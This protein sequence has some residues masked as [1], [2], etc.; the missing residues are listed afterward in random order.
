MTLAKDQAAK[1]TDLRKAPG[2]CQNIWRHLKSLQRLGRSNQIIFWWLWD[3]RITFLRSFHVP[4]CLLGWVLLESLW[5]VL[6]GESRSAGRGKAEGSGAWN[7]KLGTGIPPNGV[8]P[9]LY[10]QA[11]WAGGFK[12]L[13]GREILLMTVPAACWGALMDGR[14]GI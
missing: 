2:C 3:S 4:I 10:L 14:D 9:C 6:M 7:H 5:C 8:N 13:P 1:N 11:W 12:G